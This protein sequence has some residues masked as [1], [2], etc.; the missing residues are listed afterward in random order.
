MPSSFADG[1]LS[2]PTPATANG[3]GD[4]R[5][6]LIRQFRAH[7]KTELGE[8]GDKLFARLATDHQPVGPGA[9]KQE[10]TKALARRN[11]LELFVIGDVQQNGIRQLQRTTLCGP[12]FDRQSD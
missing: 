5:E 11:H 2:A 12:G 1:E 6:L 4:L 8:E 7:G 10:G 3:S 9:A